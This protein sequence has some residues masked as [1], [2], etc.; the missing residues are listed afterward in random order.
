MRFYIKYEV[1]LDSTGYIDILKPEGETN[2]TSSK[3]ERELR[4]IDT[5]SKRLM[6]KINEIESSGDITPEKQAE[7]DA[8]KKTIAEYNERRDTIL[9]SYRD[10]GMQLP[11]INR[12]MNATVHNAGAYEVSREEAEDTARAYRNNEE[13][14][15]ASD[16]LAEV[17]EEIQNVSKK[18]VALE[19]KIVTAEI[20]GEDET[21]A[22][23]EKDVA[24]LR[25]KRTE[26]IALAKKIRETPREEPKPVAAP[27]VDAATSERLDKIES[28]NRALRS[29]ISSV[30]TDVMDMKE[31]LRQILE[32]LGI[33]RENQ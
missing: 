24:E 1:I 30:R 9:Q 16:D 5:D 4:F 27:V 7:I 20:M 31:S 32:A 14:E 6:W 10:T 23:L 25:N 19:D 18:I 15:Y 21:K 28:D 8:M 22:R 17:T 11:N 26:L 29:Q 33:D 2:M 12:T 3:Y 13:D